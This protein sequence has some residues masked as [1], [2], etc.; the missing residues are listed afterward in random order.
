MY[1]Y[2]AQD[3]SQLESRRVIF[4]RQIERNIEGKLSDEAFRPL[5]LQQGLYIQRQAPMLRIAVPYGMLGA[6]QLRTLAKVAKEFDKGY[7]H[8]TTRQNI[9]LNW[10][11]IEAVPELLKTLAQADLH[12]IQTSGNCIRNIT[13][14]PFA[15]V[16]GDELFDPRPYCEIIRQ[17]S[18]GHPEFA[19]L[20]R[21]FKIAISGSKEDRAITQAHDIGLR[22]VLNSQQERGFQIIVGGGLGRTPIL[23]SVLSLFVPEQNILDYLTAIIRVYNLYG[24]RDNKYKA[25]IKILVKSIGID[26]F[27]QRVEQELVHIRAHSQPLSAEKIS[28]V[29]AHFPSPVYRQFDQTQLAQLHLKHADKPAFLNWFNRNTEKHKVDGYRIVTL[30][31]KNAKAAPGDI[32][33]EQLEAIADL[34]ERFSFG[35]VRSTH[36]QNIVFAD[37]PIIELFE[38]WQALEIYDLAAPNVGTINDIICCPGLAFCSLANAESIPVALKIQKTFDD[39]DYV[40]ELGDL[41]LNISGCMNACSHHHLA[42]IGILGVDKKGQQFYQISLG[43]TKGKQ[44]QLGKILG[45]SFAASAVTGII[46]II[47]QTYINHRQDLEN[48]IDTYAR[49]GIATFKEAVYEPI[50]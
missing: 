15:G 27:K 7:C 37:V 10:V 22:A 9:Q 12:S 38:L 21:K 44:P 13:S 8:I 43:G 25:R 40:Y 36:Q 16:A 11:Q 28:A 5:R 17:W 24:R 30:S 33:S 39:L 1:Q 6:K 18:L 32:R 50:N 35:E 41:S 45:P 29:M 26:Q 46:E 34:A 14:D 48:F 4:E 31:L 3:R 42:N 19:F 49:I 47:I 2:N 20:P 23:G